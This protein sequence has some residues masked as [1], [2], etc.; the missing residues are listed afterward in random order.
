M[1]YILTHP[2]NYIMLYNT[3]HN[4]QKIYDC[5]L[6]FTSFNICQAFETFRNCVEIQTT[7]EIIEKMFEYV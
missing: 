1:S 7:M 2:Y 5:D 3:I 6:T 4:Y